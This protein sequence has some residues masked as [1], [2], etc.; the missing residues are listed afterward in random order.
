MFAQQFFAEIN[1]IILEKAK[2]LK[3]FTLNRAI[4]FSL[5]RMAKR[6]FLVFK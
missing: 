3:N 1:A 5:S 6:S 4:T 2:K